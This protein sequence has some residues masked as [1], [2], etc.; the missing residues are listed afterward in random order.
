[1][2]ASAVSCLIRLTT[3]TVGRPELQMIGAAAQPLRA[4]AATREGFS[5]TKI[6]W[7]RASAGSGH[8]RS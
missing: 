4:A 6:A 1:M 8:R 5:K 7:S 3:A 2:A